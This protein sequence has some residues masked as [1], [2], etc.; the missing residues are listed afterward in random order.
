MFNVEISFKLQ[1][2]GRNYCTLKLNGTV[3][4]DS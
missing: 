4:M 3:T 1:R 2:V